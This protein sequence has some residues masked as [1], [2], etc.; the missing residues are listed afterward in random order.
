RLHRATCS[1]RPRSGCGASASAPCR[2]WT[3]AA[4]SA[5][6]RAAT[7]S[8]RSLRSPRAQASPKR[9][10]RARGSGRRGAATACDPG[11]GVRYHAPVALGR[12]MLAVLAL[13]CVPCGAGRAAVEG[14]VRAETAAIARL[15][16]A[17]GPVVLDDEALDGERLR[18][19]YG[20][21]GDTPL[22]TAGADAATRTAVLAATFGDAGS[23][24]LDPAAYHVSG[25]ERRRGTGDPV[26]AAELDVLLTDALL[27]YAVDVHVGRA[28]PTRRGPEVDVPPRSLDPLAAVRE[29][30]AAPDLR[31]WLE[32]LPPQHAEYARLR[33]LLAR[34]RAIAAAGG[35]PVLPEGPKLEVGAVGPAVATLRRRL[36]ATGDLPAAPARP[37][38]RR[39]GRRG[40]TRGAR[41]RRGDAHRPDRRQPRALALAPGRPRRALRR[42]RHS[43]LHRSA[44]RGRPPGAHHARGRGAPRPHDADS[45]GGDHTAHLQPELD[46]AD[47]DRRP[48]HA[49]A[50]PPGRVVLRERGHPRLQRAAGRPPRDRSGDRRLAPLA[51]GRAQAAPAAGAEEPARAGALRHAEHQRRLSPRLA[52]PE[53][54]SA[55]RARLQLGLRAPRR[56]ARACLAAPRRP[57]GVDAGAPRRAAR[58]LAD[59]HG[60][61]A[62][63][64]ARLSPL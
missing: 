7:C 49:R 43:G 20:E 17:P 47:D 13:A 50:H 21:H 24:G 61:A 27:R 9:R 2:W 59:A 16:A 22:W 29:A 62:H 37:R 1:P 46:R 5:S 26:V 3:T 35:W 33:A 42:R 19:L 57:A 36:A 41:R 40:D 34:Y 12:A 11:V 31:A 64:G 18:T 45:G 51:A 56:G 60:D 32:A 53:P 39:R 54:L 28:A 23:H 14:D 6:S 55:S 58:E 25:I 48:R 63:P 44:G 8:R 4:W 10:W 38:P 52:G 30:A 15:L